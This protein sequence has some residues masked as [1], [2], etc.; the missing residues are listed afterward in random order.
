MVSLHARV[1]KGKSLEERHLVCDSFKK[2]RNHSRKVIT[3]C[4][5]I[6]LNFELKNEN[7]GFDSKSSYRELGFS[8]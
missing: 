5:N 4:F 6:C 1:K 7:I 3:F 8:S 2:G